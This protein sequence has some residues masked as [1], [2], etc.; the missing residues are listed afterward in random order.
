MSLS[1]KSNA[2]RRA[3]EGGDPFKTPAFTL[4]ETQGGAIALVGWCRDRNT[5][6]SWIAASSGIRHAPA[7]DPSLWMAW[8]AILLPPYPKSSVALTNIVAGLTSEDPWR[9]TESV[10]LIGRLAAGFIEHSM[11][12]A[13]SVRELAAD[14]LNHI[15]DA[16]LRC[17]DESSR[18]RIVIATKSVAS[19]ARYREVA[20]DISAGARKVEQA[21]PVEE[22][23]ESGPAMLRAWVSQIEEG[24][25]GGTYCQYAR[26]ALEPVYA[27]LTSAP[28]EAGVSLVQGVRVG[29]S[30]K[31]GYES[32]LLAIE[33]SWLR[34]FHSWMREFFKELRPKR[35]AARWSP[36][37]L[38][39]A[40]SRLGSFEQFW[41]VGSEVD[42]IGTIEKALDRLTIPANGFDGMAAEDWRRFLDTVAEQGVSVRIVHFLGAKRWSVS[43]DASLAETSRARLEKEFT[44]V[45]ESR[46][47][48]QANNLDILYKLVQKRGDGEP[49]TAKSMGINKRQIGYYYLAAEVLGLVDDGRALLGPANQFLKL[50]GEHR[51]ALVA[52]LF[53]TS[54]VGQAWITWAE[55]NSLVELDPT[56]AEAFLTDCAR[57]LNSVTTRRRSSTLEAWARKL[58]P[59]HYVNLVS[60]LDKTE[61]PE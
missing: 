32:E 23:R 44:P 54:I 1:K 28:I 52:V 43:L 58:Q 13:V 34:L 45:V 57:G 25:G 10:P 2:L 15:P 27:H 30:S 50:E 4:A 61:E 14:G 59:F 20:E 60:A 40:A 3:A 42:G 16:A 19:N 18:R 55:V 35:D 37:S 22:W 38:T 11:Q 9:R 8:A 53:E 21:G 46:M 29:L 26:V 39:P 48:P 5:T 33:Q 7:D 31:R 12:S 6:K 56:S 17:W 24:L 36:V 49:V 41:V 47:V 51:D